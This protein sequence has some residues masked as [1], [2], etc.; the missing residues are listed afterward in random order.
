MVR[1]YIFTCTTGNTE[2]FAQK[3]SDSDL[4]TRLSYTAFEQLGP[5]P[6]FPSIT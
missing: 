5:G 4:S 2:I 3:L 6:E 1:V